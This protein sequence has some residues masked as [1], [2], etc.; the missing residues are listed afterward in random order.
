MA[1]SETPRDE[2]RAQSRLFTP[3]KIANGKIELKHRVVL[4]PLTRNRG[5]PLLVSPNASLGPENPN[6][7]WY[8]DDLVAEYYGQRASEGGLLISEGLPPSLQVCL[9]FFPTLSLS[10]PCLASTQR[11]GH[12]REDFDHTTNVSSGI[13]EQLKNKERLADVTLL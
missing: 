7:V 12:V 6:R 11:H 1:I 4:A 8:P 10:L 2:K 3:L 5:L 9:S 13:N